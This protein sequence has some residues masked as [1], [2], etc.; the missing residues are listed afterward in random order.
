MIM[1]RVAK[2][3]TLILLLLIIGNT[4]SNFVYS[5]NDDEINQEV[6]DLNEKIKNTRDRIQQIQDQQV[7]YQNNIKIKQSE[8]ASLSNQLAILE[9]RLAKAQLDIE[10]VQIEISRTNLEMDKVNLE[11][12]D[13]EMKINSEKEHIQNILKLIYKMDGKTDLEI[14]LLNNSFAEYVNQVKYLNE[15]NQEV[16]K[17]LDSL[18]IFKD[19]LEKDKIDL[20][21]KEK[22]LQNLKKDLENK[23]LALYDEQNNKTTILEE[24]ANSEQSYQRL[25]QAA[26]QEQ[27]QAAAD[28]VYLEKSVRERISKM[29][30]NKLE[31]NDAGLIWPVPKNVVTATF[32]DPDYPFRYIFE[33]PAVDIRVPQGTPLRAAAS[34]YVAQAKNGGAGYS[35]IMIIHGD[36]LATVY[37]HVSQINVKEDEYVVQ[38]QNI[39][40]SG[41][42]P[43]TPGAGKMTTGAHLHFEVRLNGIPQDPLNY[44]P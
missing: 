6:K 8:Q 32:H 4:N 24:T 37:G 18:K 22:N 14:L 40:R 3:I 11:I 17:S 35:Y 36:G 44:L 9:N 27:L 15:I 5:Q 1:K 39:G 30:G 25:L 23:K 33:H 38:G 34:G 7:V 43:G 41:G 10:S 29:L 19:E 21:D 12:S 26:R 20:T 42:L 13:K 31:F 28:I 16:G 2:I